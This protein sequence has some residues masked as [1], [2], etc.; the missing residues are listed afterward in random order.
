M[1]K[2]WERAVKAA[3]E[4]V[5]LQ[6]LRYQEPRLLMLATPTLRWNKLPAKRE[7]GDGR[8]GEALLG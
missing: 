6:L 3:Q 1:A 2:F 7:L 8:Y 4:L 5:E